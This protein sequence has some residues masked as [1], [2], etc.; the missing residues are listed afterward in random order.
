M[1][2]GL[3]GWQVYQAIRMH[4]PRVPVLFTSGYAA[5]AL[6]AGVEKRD[7]VSLIAKPYRP[8]QLL[9]AVRSAMSGGV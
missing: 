9:E 7:A 8:E 1:M 6:P 2:P 3:D 5:S 4:K